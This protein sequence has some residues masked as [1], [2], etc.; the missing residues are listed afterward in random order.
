MLL[1]GFEQKIIY[2]SSAHIVLQFAA[3]YDRIYTRKGGADI[4]AARSANV[5]VRVEPDVKEQAEAILEKLGVSV[6]S[7]INMTYRQVIL[8][9]GIPFA[10]TVPSELRTRDTMTD[11]EFDAMMAE[12]L[13]QAKA[14]QSALADEAFDRILEKLG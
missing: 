13:K 10:V 14:G 8:R 1:L 5:N 11:A 9:K 2:N 4:M 6:S 12:G 3:Q 7:F